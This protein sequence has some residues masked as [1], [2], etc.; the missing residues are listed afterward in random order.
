MK[1]PRFVKKSPAGAAA[2]RS[3]DKLREALQLRGYRVVSVFGGPD[4][5]DRSARFEPVKPTVS[6]MES[7]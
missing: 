2:I 3:V 1:G 7:L 5:S 6:Y 4:S